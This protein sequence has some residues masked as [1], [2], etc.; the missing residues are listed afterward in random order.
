MQIGHLRP[1]AGPKAPQKPKAERGEKRRTG[2]QLTQEMLVNMAIGGDAGET[3]KMLELSVLQ[4]VSEHFK[5]NPKKY[6]DVL[7]EPPFK[8]E[9]NNP[10]TPGLQNL[11][12]MVS[13]ELSTRPEWKALLKRTK[14]SAAKNA[15]PISDE[16]GFEA[17]ALISDATTDAIRKAHDQQSREAA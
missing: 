10:N 3:R 15:G 14:D 13:H 7:K 2:Q 6:L 16:L 8:V 4:A 12:Q 5:F 11:A 1:E 9:L 17:Y